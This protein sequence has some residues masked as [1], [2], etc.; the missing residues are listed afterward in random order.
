MNWNYI[1]GFFDAD[2]YITMVS[3]NKNKNKTIVVGFTNVELEI[4][5]SI[6]DFIFNDIGVKGHI[7][8]KK[9]R[10]ESHSNSYDLSYKFNSGLSVISNI[11]SKHPKKSHRK[12]IIEEN[13]LKLTPRNGKYTKELKEK[14]EKMV[15][16]FFSH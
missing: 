12:N 9:A 2:G 10:K 15:L 13:Y 14:R 1:S 16:S 3:P 7:V 11:D 4:L 8:K 6:R 5:E